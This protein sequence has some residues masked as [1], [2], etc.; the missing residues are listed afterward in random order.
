M[1]L[2]TLPMVYLGALRS[3]LRVESDSRARGNDPI[4]GGDPRFYRHFCKVFGK[5]QKVSILII[6]AFG[7]RSIVISGILQ[8]MSGAKESMILATVIYF[9]SWRSC[10]GT[11]W[12]HPVDLRKW[13]K[14]LF[15]R[16]DNINTLSNWYIKSLIPVLHIAQMPGIITPV[17][18]LL[19]SSSH[20]FLLMFTIGHSTGIILGN[21]EVDL[22]LH[23][24]Y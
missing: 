7:I 11:S 13:Y 24:T 20:L 6:P 3:I 15:Y 17:E 19:S 10:Q 22:G 12:C 9:S 4:F 1:L 2:L 5:V 23:D 18:L 14:S 8:L 16:P 21:G